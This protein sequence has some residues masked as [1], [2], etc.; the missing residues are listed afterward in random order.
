MPKNRR[1]RGQLS[2]GRKRTIHIRHRYAD[3]LE[4]P[5]KAVSEVHAPS[6]VLLEL[7]L[8]TTL[9]LPKGHDPVLGIEIEPCLRRSEES[10]C[11]SRQPAI[12]NTRPKQDVEM[13]GVLRT[14][15]VA[16]ENARASRI[17]RN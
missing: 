5:R 8:A 11:D 13:I 7:G 9:L 15:N 14:K 4:E 16:R 2:R 6:H 17:A 1:N 3:G 12:P 10:L